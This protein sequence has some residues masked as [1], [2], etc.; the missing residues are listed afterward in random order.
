MRSMTASSLARQKLPRFFSCR[1]TPSSSK[2]VQGALPESMY[3]VPR[4]NPIRP[5]QYRCWIMQRITDT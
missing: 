4:A 1:Y 5:E 3:V 2:P